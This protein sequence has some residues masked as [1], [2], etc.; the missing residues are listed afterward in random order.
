M[1]PQLQLIVLVVVCLLFIVSLL[2][3]IRNALVFLLSHRLLAEESL[4]L[5]MHYAEM[6]EGRRQYGVFER[7]RRLPSYNAMMLMFWK[8]TGSFEREVGS[9][10]QYYPLLKE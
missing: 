3:M 6:V 4:W 7:H 1:A 8:S 10:E 9:I 2:I 5:H